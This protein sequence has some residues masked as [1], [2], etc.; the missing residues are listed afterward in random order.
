VQP[1]NPT[2]SHQPQ[3]ECQITR[4]AV[5]NNMYMCKCKLHT[6]LVR[7]HYL[8]GHQVP[9]TTLVAVRVQ[10]SQVAWKLHQSIQIRCGSILDQALQ[11]QSLNV[12]ATQFAQFV[13]RSFGVLNM[14]CV[15]GVSATQYTNGNIATQCC[16][17]PRRSIRAYHDNTAWPPLLVDTRHMMDA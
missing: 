7:R 10:Q 4:C 1:L 8:A 5:M 3:L 14:W 6:T 17:S 15:G 16:A 11:Y 13:Q 9:D 12:Q 2:P